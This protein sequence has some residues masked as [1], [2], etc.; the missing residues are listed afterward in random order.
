MSLPTIQSVE[1]TEKLFQLRLRSNCFVG[2]VSSVSVTCLRL[3]LASAYVRDYGVNTSTRHLSILSHG[4]AKHGDGMAY[5]GLL[6]EA[7]C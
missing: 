7:S 5:T 1:S 2:D 6:R 4:N 3:L